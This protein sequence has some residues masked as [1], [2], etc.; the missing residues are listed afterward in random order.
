MPTISQ[1]RSD[2]FQWVI[3]DY[4]V[5]KGRLS[6][7]FRNKKVKQSRLSQIA[8]LKAFL[9]EPDNIKQDWELVQL[10]RSLQKQAGAKSTF[11]SRLMTY[12]DKY[13]IELQYGY[14]R[15]NS[16][17]NETDL[18]DAINPLDA[19]EKRLARKIEILDCQ[20][21]LLEDFMQRSDLTMDDFNADYSEKVHIMK[22]DFRKGYSD[23][24]KARDYIYR[25]SKMVPITKELT[26]ILLEEFEVQINDEFR[27]FT[28]FSLNYYI[29]FNQFLAHLKTN[30]ELLTDE[31]YLIMDVKQKFGERFNELGRQF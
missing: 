4:S 14:R 8:T 26:E 6:E 24:L 7:L 18:M 2:V 12:V 5:K 21:T 11:F 3:Q 9:L 17:V 28:D 19:Q 22:R 1:F 15:Q 10:I 20:I 16:E 31:L 30:S 29:D 27:V 23:L 25:D 13:A